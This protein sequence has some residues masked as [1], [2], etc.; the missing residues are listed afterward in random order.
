MAMAMEI[1]RGQISARKPLAKGEK[2]ECVLGGE[3]K[4]ILHR[5]LER[6]AKDGD[7]V[8]VSGPVSESGMTVLA[9]HSKKE[10]K[11]TYIDSSNYVLMMGGAG[12]LGFLFGIFAMQN[13]NI[14]DTANAV[15]TAVVSF[16][17]FVAV[18]YAVSQVGAIKRASSWVENPD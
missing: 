9:L 17:S 1:W 5:D 4:L 7:E 15:I 14:G 8:V 3:K 11:V 18:T 2:V 16:V 6:H 12:F 10:G 13:L